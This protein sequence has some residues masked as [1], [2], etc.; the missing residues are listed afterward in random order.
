MNK[1]SEPGCLAWAV[2]LSQR[3][4]DS[5]EEG[6]RALCP[7]AG[8]YSEGEEKGDGDADVTQLTEERTLERH[9][10]RGEENKGDHETRDP[11]RKG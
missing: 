8:G 3:S 5:Q 2:P 9:R 1:L 7:T 4:D 6:E 11:R 10:L